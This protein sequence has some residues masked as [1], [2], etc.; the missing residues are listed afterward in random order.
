MGHGAHEMAE[1]LK[2]IV[3]EVGHPELPADRRLVVSL[4]AEAHVMTT[5]TGGAEE[6][7]LFQPRH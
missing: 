1:D 4:P 5:D 2:T 3:N 7:M 6:V